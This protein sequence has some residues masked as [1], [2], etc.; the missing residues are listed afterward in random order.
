MSKVLESESD[1]DS[2]SSTQSARSSTDNIRGKASYMVQSKLELYSKRLS[3]LRMQSD[4]E[5]EDELSRPSQSDRSQGTIEDGPVPRQEIP[6]T[7]SLILNNLPPRTDEV[8]KEVE[9]Q[10]ES[11]TPEKIQ[12]KFQPIGSIRQ[13]SPQVCKISSTQSFSMVITFL[14]RKLKVSEVYCYINNSFAPTPQQNVGDLWTQFKI[15]E[16]LVVS[17]CSS[18]AFG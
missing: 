8:I 12:I 9:Q 5:E 14:R 3:Q 7:T 18:V 4:D 6:L 2:S 13:I 10:E 17:Y 1:Y 16:E 11:Q 15:Q